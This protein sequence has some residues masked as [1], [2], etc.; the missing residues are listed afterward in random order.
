M[1]FK[2]VRI[3]S[4][5]QIVVP[6]EIREKFNIEEG[7]YV[8]FIPLAEDL[9]LIKRMVFDKKEYRPFLEIFSKALNEVGANVEE[10]K[11]EKAFELILE[12]YSIQ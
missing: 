11:I 1:K 4:K 5:G 9:I 7:D 10:E 2:L 12:R 8:L 3:S 6:A